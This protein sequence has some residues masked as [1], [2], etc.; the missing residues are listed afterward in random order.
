MPVKETDMQYYVFRVH[1]CIHSTPITLSMQC[2]L[3][4]KPPKWQNRSL[5]DK[6]MK[7]GGMIDLYVLIIF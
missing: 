5:F 2:S 6:S 3:A 7:L 1:T 4:V